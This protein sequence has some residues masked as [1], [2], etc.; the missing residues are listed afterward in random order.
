[1]SSLYFGLAVFCQF[2][3]RVPESDSTKY[4]DDISEN[5]SS[6]YAVIRKERE[7]TRSWVCRIPAENPDITQAELNSNP[8]YLTLLSLAY[9]KDMLRLSEVV[10]LASFGITMGFFQL[11]LI[12]L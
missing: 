9:C 1:M 12:W 3:A 11:I 5:I 7:V 4:S 10:I 2:E 8:W 6:L